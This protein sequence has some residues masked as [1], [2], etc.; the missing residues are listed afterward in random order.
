MKEPTFYQRRQ[1][2][3]HLLSQFPWQLGTSEVLAIRDFYP[4][5]GRR[6]WQGK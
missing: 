3:I 1:G 2:A 4:R 5:L 6:S